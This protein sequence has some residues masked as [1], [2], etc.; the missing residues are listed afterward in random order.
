MSLTWLHATRKELKFKDW[1]N[2]LEGR[3]LKASL[4]V[5]FVLKKIG[6]DCIQFSRKM[7]SKAFLGCS[8][9][10]DGSEDWMGAL[11][12]RINKHICEMRPTVRSK[13]IRR[14]TRFSR[15]NSNI[16]SCPCPLSL[17]WRGTLSLPF[18]MC[19]FRL[20]SIFK[21]SSLSFSKSITRPR[22]LSPD[23]RITR[24]KHCFICANTFAKSSLRFRRGRS[25][26]A[27]QK[28]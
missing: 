12:A 11:R 5:Q 3:K 15:Q 28:S 27:S 8:K 7:E 6:Q 21:T 23:R 13:N 2:P 4:R 24:E 9:K 22:D 16:V 1:V 25:V 19:N 20:C 26:T 18:M 14:G 17:S 10:R